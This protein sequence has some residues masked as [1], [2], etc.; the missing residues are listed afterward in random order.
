[1]VTLHFLL[2]T[3]ISAAPV[4]GILLAFFVFIRRDQNNPGMTSISIFLLTFSLILL[5]N[6][7]S[8]QVLGNEYPLF[9]RLLGPFL[10]LIGPG[11][12]FSLRSMLDEEFR[13]RPVDFL[14]FIPFL[15]YFMHLLAFYL[16]N[17]A[18]LVNNSDNVFMMMGLWTGLFIHFLCYFM[19]SMGMLR[20]YSIKLK[21][22]FSNTKPYSL[23]WLIPV[24]IGF[25][26]LTVTEGFLLMAL[27]FRHI[28]T[29][30]LNRYLS[31]AFSIFIY[32]SAMKVLLEQKAL[33][34]I[35]ALKK[36][37]SVKATRLDEEEK[38]K[39]L[40]L[41]M[42]I[43]KEDK[44]YLDSELSLPQLADICSLT[45]HKLSDVLNSS[46]TIFYDF[47]NRYRVEEFCRLIAHPENEA[48]TLLALAMD[49]GFSSKT[50]FN[51]AFKKVM[52]QTPSQYKKQAQISE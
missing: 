36:K 15:F 17:V 7:Y 14:H 34:E 6:E 28:D 19:V 16:H 50:T 29:S 21:Q 8:S 30:Q 31:L 1:M 52:G 25:L 5:W 24:M 38:E 22:V 27:H 37:E 41:V 4:L 39:T 51:T 3:F 33:H 44:P 26:I 12:Y 9:F 2:T 10:T 49:A 18:V 23:S 11:I 35:P 45:T 13:H 47:I 40:S 20:Q 46:G 42:E 48:Y 43:M 32:Y